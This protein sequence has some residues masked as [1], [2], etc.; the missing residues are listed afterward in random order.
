MNIEIHSRKMLMSIA[1]TA[2]AFPHTAVIE[3]VTYEPDDSDFDHF[4]AHL[5][6]IFSDVV[7]TGGG[8]AM[9]DG[10]AR[11]VADFVNGLSDD[12]D[13]LF[14][15]CEA[16]MSRSAGIAAAITLAL[17]GDDWPIWRN[18]AY[19]PNSHCYRMVLQAFGMDASGA[20]LKAE[21]NLEAWNAAVSVSTRISCPAPRDIYFGVVGLCVGDALG[22]PVE[23]TPRND[24]DKYPL[25]DMAGYGIHGK[26]PGTWSDDT[27]MTLALADS[28]AAGEIDYYDI[29]RRFASWLNE[30]EYTADGKAFDVGTTT[31]RALR[32]FMAGVPSLECG[33]TRYEDNG[34][35]S[36]MRILPAMYYLVKEFGAIASPQAIEAVHNLSSLTHAHNISKIACSIYCNIAYHLMVNGRIFRELDS[37]WESAEIRRPLLHQTV[38]DAIQEVCGFYA[39]RNEYAKD[40]ALY[41]RITDRDFRHCRREEIRSSG[42]VL[43]TIEAAVWS[44]LNNDDYES[45]VLAAVNLGGDTDTTAAVAG[46]LAGLFYQNDAKVGIPTRWI[47][48][49]VNEDLVKTVCNRLSKSLCADQDVY[50]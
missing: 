6:L 42:Y 22:V 26:P 4:A 36:L 50:E 3:I 5:Q 21:T 44:L 15:S 8:N 25:D 30:G 19:S 45:T 1:K 11:Q 40:I 12:I 31:S 23:F 24:L 34:N 39:D 16:G 37:T 20:E 7:S 43:D 10:Q 49:I 46:G 48:E 35:G 33:G 28:L 2:Q 38:T 27:A 18:T 17:S 9:N 14:V 29:M 13:T 47:G 41:D 32:N